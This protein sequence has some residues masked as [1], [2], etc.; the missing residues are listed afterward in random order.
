MWENEEKDGAQ[1]K[2]Q[3]AEDYESVSYTHL[4]VYKRQQLMQE[5]GV[6][7]T[8]RGNGIFVV[9]DS[10]GLQKIQIPSHLIANQVRR[11]L[12]SLDLLA[13]TIEGTS[14][15][16]APHVTQEKMCIR[17]SPFSFFPPDRRPC[18]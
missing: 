14:A 2:R 8:V 12:D 15:C 6:V 3:T 5:W 7:K 1:V 10:A 11:Y 4:D 9:M 17:D 13:L 18:H 16:A